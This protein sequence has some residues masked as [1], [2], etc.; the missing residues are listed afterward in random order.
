MGS[1]DSSAEYP[2][3][4]ASAAATPTLIRANLGV[5]APRP[6]P[7]G[8]WRVRTRRQVNPAG[9]ILCCPLAGVPALLPGLSLHCTI[10]RYLTKHKFQDKIIKNFKTATASGH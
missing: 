6:G 2:L 4:P 7:A 3:S 8:G 10:G 1:G 5:P 9:V